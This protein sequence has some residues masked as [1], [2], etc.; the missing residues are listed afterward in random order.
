MRAE[1]KP[2]HALGAVLGILGSLL[3]HALLLALLGWAGSMPTV[4]FEVLPPS[5]VQLG[6]TEPSPLPAEP[7]QAPTASAPHAAAAPA[8]AAPKPLKPRRVRPHPSPADAG[9]ADAGADAGR[10]AGALTAADAGRPLLAAFAPAGTQI[11]L[12]LQLSRIRDS[13][14]APEVRALLEALPD[15]R[16]L[17]D[18]SGLD[19][20]RDL[21]RLYLATPDLQ[22]AS[23]VIAGQYLGGEQVPRAAVAKLA[24]ARGVSA[25]WRKHGNIPVAPWANADDTARVLALIGP[26]RFAITRPED[27]PRVLQIARALARRAG[28]QKGTTPAPDAVDALLG[29]HQG[30]ILALSVEG[31][32]QFV[33][34]NLTGVPKRIELSVRRRDEQTLEVRAS[35]TFASAAAARA[36]LRYWE[37]T[38]DRFADHPLLA[39]I[40]MRQPL[41]DTA[42]HADAERLEATT[43]VTDQQARVVLGLV[44]GAFG[45][46]E[47]DS[48]DRTPEALPSLTP[49]PSAPQ[50]QGRGPFS[51][52]GP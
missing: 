43:V 27:L 34:G 36:A 3:A 12:R 39:F 26:R 45:S 15:W 19:A 14:L 51:P 21:E 22:R 1:A 5:H 2:S 9:I 11:A 30:E 38:R 35:A 7:P 20:L 48:S 29:L 23:V 42:L 25:T 52:P 47:V 18:G 50:Q 40:G 33:R 4:D 37:S 13:D 6:L 31:A 8:P 10:D 46:T 32:Q 24:Q 17:V 44:R 49:S 41:L 16:M 28:Q